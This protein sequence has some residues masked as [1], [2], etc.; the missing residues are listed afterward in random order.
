MAEPTPGDN[1]KDYE[2]KPRASDLQKELLDIRNAADMPEDTPPEL[3]KD[4][5]KTRVQDPDEAH[6]MAKEGNSLRSRAALER[7]TQRAE[8]Y[9]RK[10]HR[11]LPSETEK[12]LT[13][14]IE[15][16]QDRVDKIEQADEGIDYRAKKLVSRDTDSLER[17]R[18]AHGSRVYSRGELSDQY[19]QGNTNSIGYEPIDSQGLDYDRMAQAEKYDKAAEHR[20]EVA[21]ILHHNPDAERFG[22]YDV[23]SYITAEATIPQLEQEA[24]FIDERVASIE[25]AVVEGRF[26]LYKLF[27]SEEEG[28]MAITQVEDG[29]LI[30]R[31]RDEVFAE[32]LSNPDTT[33]AELNNAFLAKLRPQAEIKRELAAKRKA[34][35]D[36]F[37]RNA[38]PEAA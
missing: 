25:A 10:N 22:L 18:E 20:E 38:F 31:L 29:K 36:E 24:D 34:K 30:E 6:A 33:V 13:D 12:E 8:D 21:Q 32:L 35:M 17:L 2:I 11:R 14:R 16:T 7:Q 23:D 37:R 19:L 15:S 4:E 28:G 1:G 3:K 26:N 9:Q 27:K 5:E